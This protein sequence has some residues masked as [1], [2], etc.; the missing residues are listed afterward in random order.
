M[1]P[2]PL[3]HTS[4]VKISL[5]HVRP[6]FKMSK[7]TREVRR[8]WRRKM[9]Q[10]GKRCGGLQITVEPMKICL[11]RS[12]YVGREEGEGGGFRRMM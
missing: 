7:V 4:N 9:R 11:N 3:I 2:L 10:W 6:K 5:V 1:V 12:R 8:K